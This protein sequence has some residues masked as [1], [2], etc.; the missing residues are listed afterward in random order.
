MIPCG[1]KKIS[2][3]DSDK[4]DLWRGELLEAQQGEE[5]SERKTT[6]GRGHTFEDIDAGES[7][8]TILGQR[9]HQWYNHQKQK[10]L[11]IEVRE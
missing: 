7:P 4:D 10:I 3:A 1:A 6:R 8:Q 9:S 2:R 5:D 11:N